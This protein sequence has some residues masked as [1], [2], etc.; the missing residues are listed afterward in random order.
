MN[1]ANKKNTKPGNKSYVIIDSNIFQ[2]LN[3]PE[4]SKEINKELTIAL[5]AGY[6]PSLSD[7]S[8][9]ELINGA[10]PQNEKKRIKVMRKM[11]RFYVKKKVLIAAAHLGCLY[12][13]EDGVGNKCGDIGDMI[14]AGTSLLT[15]SIIYTANGRDFPRP[16]FNEIYKGLIHYKKKDTSIFL[17]TYFLKPDITLI[18]QRYTKR[19]THE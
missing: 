15:N 3:N 17:P 5:R 7:I 18:V 2:Y 12:K 6:H 13:D 10:S 4:A 8:F 9:F 14:I 16:F 19:F 1:Q 11:K